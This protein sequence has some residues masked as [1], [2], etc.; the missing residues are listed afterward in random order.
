MVMEGDID[1]IP[2][3][4]LAAAVLAVLA[5]LASIAAG[6]LGVAYRN[7]TAELELAEKTA[8]ANETRLFQILNAIP[9]ALVET[10]LSGKFVFANRTA[11]QLLGRR[12]AELIGLRFHSATWGIT[13]PDGRLI[14]PDLL[15]SARALRGQTVKGFQHII[16]HPGTKRRMLVSVTAMPIVNGVGEVIGSTAALVEIEGLNAAGAA[17]ADL[18]RRVFD[19]AASLLVVAGPEGQVREAN[20]AALEA[21]GVEAAALRGRDFADLAAAEDRR[22][23]VRA[24]IAEVVRS[25]QKPAAALEERLTAEDGTTRTVRWRALPLYVSGPAGAV[26]AVLLA[27]ED[28]TDRQAGEPAAPGAEAREAELAELAERLSR[29]EQARRAAEAAQAAAEA[30]LA[31]EQ[32]RR[33]EAEAAARSR[34]EDSRRLEDV[35]RLAGGV[36][37]DF[38][39]LLTVMVGALDL[40]GRQADSPERVR[41]IADAALAAGR[42]GERLTR[43][44]AAFS[45][46][47]D[48]ALRPLDL[49]GALRGLP[50][51]ERI[52]P[53][54]VAMPAEPLYARFDPVRLQGALVALAENAR[55]AQPEGPLE[56]RVEAV[57]LE[58]GDGPDLPPGDWVRVTLTDRGPGMNSDVLA[59]AA[60]P[61][62]TTK[63]RA[64]G[65]GLAQ[66][67]GFARSAGGALRLESAPGEGVRASLWL[68]RVAT[69]LV[70]APP[71]APPPG[72]GAGPANDGSEPAPAAP[73]LAAG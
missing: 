22:D 26:D 10:D 24:A 45:R 23:A 50:V 27:G 1:W 36:A 12:D 59:R 56:L 38:N 20:R 64:E 66:A 34:D 31:V 17:E 40:I 5:G 61:F 4:A 60:E 54:A 21:L 73:S 46:G 11:H 28:V 48:H 25:G 72:G 9:V 37:H 13:Y 47:D 30:A 33:T 55:D 51:P 53:V 63:P 58:T 6:R 57:R 49:T 42:R 18:T 3:L 32:T 62:F 8:R 41:R 69:P 19:A 52:G 14:P 2:L 39:S 15:P 44:L 16:A 65:L 29:A 67:H 68:P 7:A 71:P 70:A 35:G 43:Q